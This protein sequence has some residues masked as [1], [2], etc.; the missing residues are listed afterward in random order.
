[1]TI[2]TW[3]WIILIAFSLILVIITPYVKENSG[4]YKGSS[5]KAEKPCFIMLTFSLVISWIFAKSITNAANLGL[6]FGIVGG[7]AYAAYYC[8]FLVAGIVIYKMR[9]KLKV[10]SLHQFLHKKFGKTAVK[11]FTLVIAIRLLNEVWSNS[12]VI[13][14]YFGPTGST[15]YIISIAVF[16][17]LTLAYALKGGLRSSLITDLLQMSLFVILLVIVLNIIIPEGGSVS[18][19]VSTGEWSLSTGVNLLLV[20]LIQIFSYPFHDPVMTDR[21]FISDE[22]TTLKSFIAST[23]IGFTA[24]LL[25]SFVGIYAQMLGLEGQAAVEVSKT[26]GVFTTIIMN[27]IMITSASSTIDSTFASVSKMVV[28][29]LGKKEFATVTKGRLIMIIAAIVGTIPL[30][31]SPEILSATTISGTMVLGLAP[32]FIFWKMP[33]PKISFHLAVWTGVAAGIILTF[34]LLPD[35][36]YISSGK[37]ADLLSINVYAMSLILILYLVPAFVLKKNERI[38]SIILET[39]PLDKIK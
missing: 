39:I 37:Y 16:T 14:T 30:F 12:E 17:V 29:D 35:S 28:I 22:K 19:F 32:I 26:L 11:V 20:A 24:I 25:F 8:S 23:V 1:M 15:P 4:F 3:Q 31:F 10:E 18:N 36:L 33:A 34:G 13:G 5:K 9:T 21:G 2:Q 27:F 6:S 7:V 38:S